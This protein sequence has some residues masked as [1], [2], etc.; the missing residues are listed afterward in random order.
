MSPF[1]ALYERK[2]RSPIHWHEARERKFLGPE[3]VG[4]VSK[5]MK[6]IKKRLQ[7]FVDRHKK[8]TKNR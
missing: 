3:E 8:Y 1:E 4:V 2:C 5:E 7:A 6:T